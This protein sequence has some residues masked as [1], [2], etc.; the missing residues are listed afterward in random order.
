[1]SDIHTYNDGTKKIARKREEKEAEG[2]KMNTKNMKSCPRKKKVTYV[3][4]ACQLP[5]NIQNE[6]A[7]RTLET[8]KR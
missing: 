2:S 1:M 4:I 3:P 7:R 8:K 6:A 5:A